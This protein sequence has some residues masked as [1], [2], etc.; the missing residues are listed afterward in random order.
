METQHPQA[1]KLAHYLESPESSDHDELRRHLIQ[2]NECRGQIDKLARMELG[3]KNHAARFTDYETIADDQQYDIEK[4]VDGELHG[5]EQEQ[6]REKLE[7]SETALKSALHYAVHSAAMARKLEQ[8]VKPASHTNADPVSFFASALKQ[9]KSLL[10]IPLPAWSM[11][12]ASLAIAAII[13]GILVSNVNDSQQNAMIAA[14]QDNPSLSYRRD[15]IPAGSIGFFHDAHTRNTPF[16]GMAIKFENNDLAMQWKPIDSASKYKVSIY[17]ITPAGK[18]EIA[19]RETTESK[20]SFPNVKLATHGHYQWL[21]NGN[22]SDN[23]LFE[24]S[25]DF[26]YSP[27]SK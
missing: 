23:M 1:E 11:V 2:C 10:E 8:T 5:N 22:T 16:D 20:I 18:N 27:I 9:L 6:I 24:T 12:P 17:E 3:I 21:L 14:F 19:S 4:Y 26:I 15:G 25:G 7:S 13:S